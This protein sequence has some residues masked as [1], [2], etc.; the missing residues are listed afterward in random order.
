M[1]EVGGI[2]GERLRSFIERIERLEEER[3][4][5]GSDIKEVYAEAKGNGFDVVIM[6]QL[7][8]LRR[9]DKDDLDEQET[10]IDVYKRALGMLPAAD[11]D[12]VS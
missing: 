11:G 2:A 5:L 1:P 8:R 6:R 7:I 4:T 12:E 9:L 10:L 3:R